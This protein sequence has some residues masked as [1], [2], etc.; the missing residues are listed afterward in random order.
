MSSEGCARVRARVQIL[1][2]DLRANREVYSV[3]HYHCVCGR[4]RVHAAS[5]AWGVGGCAGTPDS[6]G[7]GR[8]SVG[9][10]GRCRQ[11]D[12]GYNEQG[13]AAP[14]SVSESAE[15][16]REPP[17]PA[18][19][20]STGGDERSPP[21]SV[22]VDLGAALEFATE[23]EAL[24]A[25]GSV[26]YGTEASERAEGS[27]RIRSDSDADGRSDVATDG[28]R[29]SLYAS[30]LRGQAAA[31]SALLAATAAAAKASRD[32]LP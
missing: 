22:L 28:F 32:S 27:F 31:N 20:Q 4:L 12:G 6:E 30:A 5:M 26:A 19:A 18:D 9:G 11:D 10:G 14:R 17:S 29:A 24:P 8:H 21:G 25:Y 3:T 2:G 16:G 23:A 15:A 1:H 13:P 7:K